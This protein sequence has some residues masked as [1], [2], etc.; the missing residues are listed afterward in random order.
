LLR[1]GVGHD[2]VETRDGTQLNEE[3]NTV[4]EKVSNCDSC[5]NDML[6]KRQEADP[7]NDIVILEL[8]STGRLFACS[9]VTD[10]MCRGDGLE[11][12]NVLD[13]ITETYDEKIPPT[14]RK[15]S[16]NDANIDRDT[17]HSSRG[18]PANNRIPYKPNHPKHA[19]VQRVVRGTGHNTL[20]NIIGKYLPRNDDRETYP[21]YCASMLMLLQ[22]WRDMAVDL[23]TDEQTWE[24]A[25]DEFVRTTTPRI[26]RVISNIQYFHA[27]ERAAQEQRDADDVD[28][29]VEV[30][31]DEAVHG[32]AGDCDMED[33]DDYMD[34]KLDITEEAIEAAER[35]TESWRETLYGQL[36]IE[37]ARKANI[38]TST[39]EQWP[40][41]GT[42][43][44]CATKSDLRQLG[45]WRK[46]M[47]DDIEAQNE[48]QDG[49]DPKGHADNDVGPSVQC[50]GED[51]I[52]GSGNNTHND[53]QG[54]LPPE[55]PLTAVE[56][57]ELN[58]EQF[59]AFDIIRRHLHL[60][61]QGTPPPPLR[62]ITHGEG[63]TGKSQVIQNVTG[64]FTARNVPHLLLKS[65]YTGIAASLVKGKTTH[66]I[67]QLLIGKNDTMSD[68]TKQRLQRIWK[69]VA[70]LVIDEY[71]MLSKTF[72]AR[73]SRAIS[74][75][76]T[77]GEDVI[78]GGINV[79]LCGDLHQFPPVASQGDAL[80]Y[81]PTQEDSP[82][83][84]LGWEIYQQFQT[85]VTLTQQYRISDPEWSDFLRHLRHG[86]VKERHVMLLRKQVVGHPDC[87][88][89]DFQEGDWSTAPLVTPR[90]SVRVQWNAA[91]LRRWCEKTG[92]RLLIC[93]AEDRIKKRELTKLERYAAAVRG[94]EK[95]KSRSKQ[96]LPTTIEIAKGMQ[97]MVTTN[98]QTDL[99]I[100][101]G[102]RGEIVDIVL[103]PEEPSLPDTP[104]VK[105]TRLPAYLLVKLKRTRATQ[106][107]GLE[108]CVIPVEPTAVKFQIKV[109][110]KGRKVITRTVTRMQFPITGAYAFTDYRS[111]G[112]T[113][114]RVIVDIA[115]VPTG[116]LS[117]FNLY[118]ALSRSHGRDTIRLLRDFDDATFQK[119]H[120][121]ELTDED[122]RLEKLDRNTTE[123][124]QTLAPAI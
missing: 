61:L 106:L 104:I 79:I 116:G 68:E 41:T 111:Q 54:E 119:P 25:F 39:N 1:E 84:K 87:P 114:P 12:Y 35:G 117:L 58:T 115:K 80:F 53:M 33:E 15:R 51:V 46:Q 98:V 76:V 52:E 92:E 55:S 64:A 20:P 38:F 7:E 124:Y 105:L 42:A 3:G 44:H 4:D 107:E 6:T 24:E 21:F 37:K 45:Q 122:K 100:A 89:T 59:R 13:F 101:N 97:V 28:I 9:Q 109:K 103:H 70:Y 113:I 57:A 90:H 81:P 43:I 63:G 62:M 67:G 95:R 91:A 19:N 22:P 69:D 99:D 96:G 93:R 48:K 27:C 30:E 110:T 108:E 23:K 120:V 83:S 14:R 121:S 49:Q 8:D 56:A 112:Q 31:D 65:A 18:R 75:A 71:S 82:D 118:V 34:D 10:Y 29:E 102:A 74:M 2:G 50:I 73:L 88:K 85:V 36:A 60:T 5:I 78:F 123:W 32:Q 94:Q 66:F 86:D 47:E 72:L 77:G 11:D 16:G 40:V 26:R 17:N